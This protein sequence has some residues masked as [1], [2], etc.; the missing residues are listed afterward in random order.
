MFQPGD[1]IG[2]YTLVREI[3]RGSFGVVWLA[4]KRTAITTTHFAIK[5]TRDE[6]VDL[7]GFKREAAIWVQASGHPNVLPIIEADV[8]NGQIIIVSEYAPDGTLTKW[9]EKHGGKAPSVEVAANITLQIL[10]GLEHLHERRIIH[11]DIKP[12]NILLQG[13]TPRLA[14]F[15]IACLLRT[16]SYSQSNS[17]L[18][19]LR[20]AGVRIRTSSYSQSIKGTCA[21]MAPEA[22]H[23]ERNKQ[24]DVWSVGVVL[25]RMLAGRLPY[26]QL[27][28]ISLSDAI[29][30]QEPPPLPESV[31]ES[32][33]R[34]VACALQ[35]DSTLRY[36]SAADMSQA[37]NNVI[38][39]IGRSVSP[40]PVPDAH[41]I[42]K[43]ALVWLGV[44]VILALFLLRNSIWNSTPENP[45]Y[46]EVHEEGCDMSAEVRLKNNFV[47]LFNA[48]TSRPLSLHLPADNPPHHVE[49]LQF[50]QECRTLA[51]VRDDYTIDLFDTRTGIFREEKTYSSSNSSGKVEILFDGEVVTILVPYHHPRPFG[52]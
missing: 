34:V 30:S 38:S 22:F 8:H 49:K 17:E 44:L 35:R 14:D 1:S 9:L 3:G 7:E 36:K 45:V 12:S 10:V 13:K 16:D 48:R 32:L 4:E 42:R 40:P 25:Y 50:I 15:G 33:Q 43:I 31:P 5:L 2:P 11:R 37:L 28:I 6:G 39:E 51:V 20:G 18:P 27:D 24:T 23:G 52:P 29:K 26:V 41:N 19:T 47:E 46:M 21:Y